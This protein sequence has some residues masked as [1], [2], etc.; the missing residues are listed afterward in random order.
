MGNLALILAAP[1]FLP[2]CGSGALTSD[3][4]KTV[5]VIALDIPSTVPQPAH[6]Y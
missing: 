2:G 1:A 5:V 3:G 4:E 6:G